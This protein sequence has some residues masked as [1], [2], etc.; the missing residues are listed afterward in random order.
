M[1]KKEE[2]KWKIE[3]YRR[4]RLRYMGIGERA[5]EGYEKGFQKEER[6]IQRRR[7]KRGREGGESWIE[8]E[9]S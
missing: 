7:R 4:R 5:R 1:E 9:E 2:Y 8:K 6:D 3:N